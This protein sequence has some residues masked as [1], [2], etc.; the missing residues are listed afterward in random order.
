M[1]DDNNWYQAN[2]RK[3]VTTTTMLLLAW[4]AIS[5]SPGGGTTAYGKKLHLLVRISNVSSLG[6]GNEIK[7]ESGQVN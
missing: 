6:R 3:Q 5:I 4:P 7:D 2:R 1:D